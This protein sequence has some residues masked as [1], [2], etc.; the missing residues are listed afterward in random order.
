MEITQY[1]LSLIAGV[2]LIEISAYCTVEFMS[3]SDPQEF[4]DQFNSPTNT[5]A[6]IP[7]N[8]VK[9]FSSLISAMRPKYLKEIIV[10]NRELPRP[11]S[12]RNH[13]KIDAS[14]VVQLPVNSIQVDGRVV[15]AYN[16]KFLEQNPVCTQITLPS[17]DFDQI[18][19]ECL[20][21]LQTVYLVGDPT[22]ER[23]LKDPIIFLKKE[24]YNA[25]FNGL[26]D[27]EIYLNKQHYATF[28]APTSGWWRKEKK[29]YVVFDDEVQSEMDEDTR[30][31]LME[32]LCP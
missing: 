6:I 19:F 10:T 3:E 20:P 31:I 14:H 1:M 5:T 28:H 17:Y 4:L 23:Y 18:L 22:V 30:D 7:G 15:D 8:L 29:A 21:N 12:R 13:V 27:V 2:S 9:P 32:S 11:N 26:H 25:R 24:I 16:R